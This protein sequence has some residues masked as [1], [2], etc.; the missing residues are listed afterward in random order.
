M[1]VRWTVRAANDRGPQAENRIP[2]SPPNV[3]GNS[4][5]II[6]GFFLFDGLYCD[7]MISTNPNS[8]R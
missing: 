6:V 7:K 5:R 4:D 2:C 1:T 3:H 8:T